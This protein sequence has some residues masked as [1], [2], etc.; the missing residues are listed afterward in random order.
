VE[1]QTEVCRTDDA[2]EEIEAEYLEL[3][4]WARPNA[5]LQSLRSDGDMEEE[6]CDMWEW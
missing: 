2:V 1:S 6:E 3:R 4:P 5:D